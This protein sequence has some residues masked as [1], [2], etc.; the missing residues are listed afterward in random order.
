M[1]RVIAST[2]GK[3]ASE[4]FP[5]RLGRIVI[6][7]PRRVPGRKSIWHNGI[8]F[9]FTPTI[10]HFESHPTLRNVIRFVMKSAGK[11]TSGQ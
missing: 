3:I 1:G 5:N 2:F 9:D 4:H 11:F 6:P 7:V 8:G 10:P